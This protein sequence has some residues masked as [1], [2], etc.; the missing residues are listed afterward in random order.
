MNLKPVFWKTW[1]AVIVVLVFSAFVLVACSSPSASSNVLKPS[2]AGGTG[3]AVNLTGDATA[4]ATVFTTNCVACHG[5][6]G[7]AGIAN[8]G[9]DKGNVPNLN[10]VDPALKNA[11]AKV[12][13][14]NLD[15]FIEH[16]STP[17]GSSPALQMKAWG[18][19]KLLTS[20]QI[21]DVIAYVISLNK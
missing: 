16:G 19:Q 17:K 13:A 20:Q 1:G 3:D 10:P 11:D 12:F 5:D 8:P 18:D 15:L 2:N 6:Q 14:A 4:G 7:K 21:A 9:S